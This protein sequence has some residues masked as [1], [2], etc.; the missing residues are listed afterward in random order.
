[1]I[2]LGNGSTIRIPVRQLSLPIKGPS[3]LR[4]RRTQDTPVSAL[5]GSVSEHVSAGMP[6]CKKKQNMGF[7]WRNAQNRIEPAV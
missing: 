4:R 1:M 6:E 2:L 7:S 3:P 5:S